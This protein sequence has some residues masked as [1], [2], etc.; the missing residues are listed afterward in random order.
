MPEVARSS[1]PDRFIEAKDL[2]GGRDARLVEFFDGTL[3]VRR[4]LRE[5]HVGGRLDQMGAVV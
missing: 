4:K 2:G 3:K 5:D 1:H